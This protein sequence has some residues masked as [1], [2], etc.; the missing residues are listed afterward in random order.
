MNVTED[1]R[2]IVQAALSTAAHGR[3][4]V[5]AHLAALT[6]PQ[7]LSAAVALLTNGLIVLP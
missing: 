6:T 4:P 5:T 7:Q 1:V 3:E 2:R